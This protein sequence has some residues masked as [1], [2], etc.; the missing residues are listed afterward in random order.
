MNA[1]TMDKMV[2]CSLC[3]KVVVERETCSTL[4]CRACHVTIRFED[5]IAAMVAAQATPLTRGQVECCRTIGRDE[6][7]RKSTIGLSELDALCDTALLGIGAL[8]RLAMM[9]RQR[10]AWE[11]LARERG[12]SSIEVR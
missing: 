9:Q 7:S 10:D 3:G 6:T 12:A 1:D 2:T 5:C 4:A 8:E 11:K